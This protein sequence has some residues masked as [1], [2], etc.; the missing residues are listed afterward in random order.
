V[1]PSIRQDNTDRNRTSPIAFTG[2]KFEFRMLGSSQSISGPNIALNTI[3]AEELEEFADQLE[4]S[5]DFGK[6]LPALIRKTLT[7]HQR[8]IF[9]GN[10]YDD[11]WLAEAEKRGLA[12][13]KSTAE[14]LPAYTAKKN[15]DLFTKHGI[16][17]KTEIKA[18]YEIH[19]ENYT[20]VIGIEANTMV[21][22]IRHQILPAV[23]GYATDLCERADSKSALGVA[24]KYEKTT[25][26]E[27]AKLTDAL[28]DACT[29]LEKDRAKVPADARKAMEYSHKTLVGDMAA[30]R[31]IA[32]RLETLTASEYWP[33]PVYSDLLFSV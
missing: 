26:A 22:M 24:C 8:I 6:D 5:K 30:A 25:A 29:R 16:Y 23:S 9:N 12:N 15:V 31:E 21:D 1:L 19:I 7:D 14:A 17:T 3:M 11:A 32:D 27:V 18:R 13:L 10:G 20:T 28:L 4:Q 33:F 2:N